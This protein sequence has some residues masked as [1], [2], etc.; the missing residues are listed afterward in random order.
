ME[1]KPRA[2]LGPLVLIILGVLL[3][4]GI[5]LFAFLA[6]P[7]AT[8]PATIPPSPTPI[9]LMRGIFSLL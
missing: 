8:S 7:N 9:G 2:E 3:C 6:P 4:V 1:A 5:M